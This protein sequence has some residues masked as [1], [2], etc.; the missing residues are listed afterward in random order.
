MPLF[1]N[2]NTILEGNG[3]PEDQSD[4]FWSSYLTTEKGIYSTILTNKEKT[5]SGKVSDLA[6]RFEIDPVLFTGFLDGINTSLDNPLDLNTLEA[7]SEVNITIDFE[8]LFFNMH[9]AK[10]DWLYKLD[11][12]DDI[13]AAE[14]KR[15]IKQSYQESVMVRVEKVGRND[16]C[17]CGSGKKYKKCCLNKK[18]ASIS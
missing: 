12:W 2:W 4:A 16:P 9:V 5:L 6:D 10:A 18:E 17:P 14:K 15:E 3:I 1:E 11:A 8:K 13:L 7:E